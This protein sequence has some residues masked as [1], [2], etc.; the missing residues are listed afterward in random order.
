MPTI[1]VELLTG[2]SADQKRAF[3]TVVVRE[4]ASILRCTPADVQVV[5]NEV[6]PADWINGGQISGEPAA[7]TAKT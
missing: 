1:R 3:A 5:F 6:A 2:R 4:A 7:P